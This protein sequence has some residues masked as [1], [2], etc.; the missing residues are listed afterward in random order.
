M[1]R[2]LKLKWEWCSSRLKCNNIGVAD[3]I[4]NVK[5]KNSKNNVF[6]SKQT[7]NKVLLNISRAFEVRKNVGLVFWRLK[8]SKKEN[9]SVFSS[10]KQRSKVRLEY[11]ERTLQQ[12][13]YLSHFKVKM[14]ENGRHNI[15][16]DDQIMNKA[17]LIFSVVQVP[18]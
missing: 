11:L 6:R 8:D 1:V 12:D 14:P 2:T 18:T 7:T 3:V 15:F 4:R 17:P 13:S 10:Y 16:R 9:C 5:L